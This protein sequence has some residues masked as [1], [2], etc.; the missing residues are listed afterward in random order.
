MNGSPRILIAGAGI[1]GLTLANA[2]NR[3]G[4][5]P[6]LVEAA[7]TLEPP[8]LGLSLQP[9]G[10]RALDHIDLGAS[11][12]AGGRIG[13]QMITT[14]S[15][16]EPIRTMDLTLA[17][18]TVALHRNAL[19]GPLTANLDADLR[20][21]TTIA[22]IDPSKNSAAV[23]LSDG[24]SA[25]FDLVVGADGL[26]SALRRQLF[27]DATFEYRN[28]R[29]WRTVVPRGDD[30]P[31]EAMLRWSTGA[32]FGT[33]PVSDEQL[34]TFV[35]EHG[36]DDEASE[37]DHVGHIRRI[38]EQFGP[39]ARS[40]AR[41]VE[42]ST[43]TIYTPVYRVHVDRWVRAAVVLLGDAAHAIVPMLAQGAAL[44]IEDAV[45]LAEMI[46]GSATPA[47][48]AV[49]YEEARRPRLETVAAICGFA[50]LASGIEGPPD[51]E[52]L[53]A[54]PGNPRH[55]GDNPAAA[56]DLLWEGIDAQLR[57]A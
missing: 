23:T 44:A 34:Y 22:A 52:L 55:F 45:L 40:A 39:T 1:A 24:S 9:N 26:R 32:A 31:P 11:V 20:L 6:V 48:A 29:A 51:R 21:E 13:R 35:L 38:A 54:H 43:P 14:N 28:C 53:R 7:S 49:A 27:P 17:G 25:V 47:A 3:H 57:E 41:R 12:M 56:Q 16:E 15:G 8:G 33:F 50:S 5:R 18:P 46:V 19:I 36:P 10:V 37:T 4:I 42:P 2:L 30:D